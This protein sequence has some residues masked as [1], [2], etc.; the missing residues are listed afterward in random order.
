ML[1]AYDLALE[2]VDLFPILAYNYG[3]GLAII[4]D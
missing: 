1:V 4:E 3:R 2:M